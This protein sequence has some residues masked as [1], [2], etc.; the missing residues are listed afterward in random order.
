MRERN[1]FLYREQ[2]KGNKKEGTRKRENDRKN[3][4]ERSRKR[5]KE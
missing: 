5:H 4:K 3:K 2:D 1:I